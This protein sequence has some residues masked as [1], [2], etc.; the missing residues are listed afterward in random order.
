MC[1]PHLVRDEEPHLLSFEDNI[2]SLSK[3]EHPLVML[4][5][6]ACFS[7]GCA[8]Y[9]MFSNMSGFLRWA[10]QRFSLS[11]H[12]TPPIQVYLNRR[13]FPAACGAEGLAISVSCRLFSCFWPTSNLIRA[14]R[15]LLMLY[16]EF[17]VL[18][19]K[20]FMSNNSHLYFTK[21]ICIILSFDQIFTFAV[22]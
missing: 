10:L 15:E 6:T 16:V 5:A 17:D 18:K 9:Q 3:N 4:A 12:F 21:I 14:S 8:T 2:W 11:A 20:V 7:S 13:S 22:K 19:L 1:L